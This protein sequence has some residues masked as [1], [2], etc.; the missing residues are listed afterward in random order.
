VTARSLVTTPLTLSRPSLGQACPQ[1]YERC[2]NSLT[3]FEADTMT[4][5]T[6]ETFRLS[7]V[8]AEGWNMANGLATR[9]VEAL[10]FSKLATLNPYSLEPDRTRWTSGFTEALT[11]ER[12]V[13]KL[14]KRS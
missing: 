7:R 8:Y 6:N 12:P 2:T 3:Q 5:T 4:V 14:R 9:E 11:E 13:T 10:D 1:H